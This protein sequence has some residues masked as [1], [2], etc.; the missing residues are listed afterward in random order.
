[1]ADMVTLVQR[2]SSNGSSKKQRATLQSLGLGRIG[3]TAERPDGAVLRGQV[4]AVAH[5][6]EVR[7]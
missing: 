1:M 6:V 5:L 4:A 2:R 3:R 7:P